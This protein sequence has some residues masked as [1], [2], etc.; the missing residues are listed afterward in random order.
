MIVKLQTS[1]KF[2]CSSTVDPA[3]TMRRESCH[4]TMKYAFRVIAKS[5]SE[6][7][8][9]SLISTPIDTVIGWTGGSSNLKQDDYHKQFSCLSIICNSQH[10]LDIIVWKTDG[11]GL[12]LHAEGVVVG[13][14]V[15]AG[16]G[17]DG[18]EEYYQ[19]SL[20]IYMKIF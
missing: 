4:L 11:L 1:R 5:L 6:T 15:L 16:R 14:V 7:L 12:A 17:D 19:L 3:W 8:G 2:V 18:E 13:E 9:I 10:Y 20:R